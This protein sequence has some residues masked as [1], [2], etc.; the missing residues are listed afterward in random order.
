MS[1]DAHHLNKTLGFLQAHKQELQQ[2]IAEKQAAAD[3][4]QAEHARLK[5]QHSMLA[6]ILDTQQTA[7][8]ILQG[9]EQVCCAVPCRKLWRSI[10]CCQKCCRGISPGNGQNL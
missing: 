3:A 7:V 1:K 5:G 10:C 6:R 4:L 9:Q 2:Q 8:N